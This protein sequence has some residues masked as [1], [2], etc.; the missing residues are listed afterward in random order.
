MIDTL[1]VWLDDGE[2]PPW[3]EPVGTLAR[4]RA[5]G[6]EA[7]RFRYSASWL[8]AG[9]HA[10][11]LDPELPLSPGDF[12][13]GTGQGLHRIF[14]D[15]APD[16][17]GR[18]LMERREADLARREKRKARRLGEWDFLIGVHDAAR[19]GGLRLRES[20]SGRWLDDHA[21]A[22][23]PVARLRELEAAARAL[24]EEGAESRPEYSQWLRTLMVPGSSLG[25]ARPKAS[26]LETDGSLWL[27]KFP[28]S[29]DRHDLGAWE[30][31]AHQLAL[32]A[33]V[34]APEAR[35][36][37]FGSR[38]HTFCVHRFDRVTAGRRMYASAMT[39]LQ[40]NDGEPAS[41]L[42]LAEGLQKQGDAASLETDLH[43]L[44]RRIA[45]FISIGNRDDH[46][47]NHGFLRGR[48][49]W[50][51][52]PAFDL[53]PAPERA[54]HVLAID[55]TDARP[56]LANLR[57]T[58]PF[59]RLNERKA[60]RIESAVRAAVATWHDV[61]LTLGIGPREREVLATLLERDPGAE[62]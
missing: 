31:L 19:L 37:R 49:G 47:R 45:F 4:T 39:L 34:E 13:P 54:E 61:A 6:H 58:A 57:A 10:F 56:S 26:F 28:A 25:G 55:E 52:A 20:A 48:T 50:C 18:M 35:L 62:E 17:W 42:E 59:Y 27:A 38:H 5:R 40:R 8:S 51:L 16:R 21:E 11:A 30:Y 9:R 41:Y 24:D 14:R 29:A 44:Y 36:A 33:G 60:A 43:Q 46:L 15:S 53:N 1:E 3:K 22:I 2:L 7:V 23:P 32:A 12:H